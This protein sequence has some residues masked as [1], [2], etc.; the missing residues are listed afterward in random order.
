MEALSREDGA[1]Q[2]VMSVECQARDGVGHG[3]TEVC[4]GRCRKTG[5]GP[6]LF[7]ET[8]W[9]G[10]GTPWEGPKQASTTV[11]VAHPRGY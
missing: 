1:E 6:V 10:G 9:D 8:G 2:A 3:Q 7:G 4:G 5:A 11:T